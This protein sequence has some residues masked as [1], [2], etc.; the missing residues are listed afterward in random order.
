MRILYLSRWFPIPADNGARVRTLNVLKQ[1]SARHELTLLSFAGGKPEGDALA[2]ARTLCE[3]VVTVPYLGFQPDAGSWRDH[4]SRAPRSLRQAYSPEMQRQ[5]DLAI[6]RHKPDVI[7]AASLE[8][9]EYARGKKAGCVLEELELGLVQ[10]A[11]AAAQSPAARTQ[12]SLNWWKL[13]AYVRSVLRDFDAVTMVSDRERRRAEPL[14]LR[15]EQLFVCAN[16]IDAARYPAPST[17]DARTPRAGSLIY[18]G[19]LTYHANLDAVAYFLT[20]IYPQI[21]RANSG[22]SLTVTGD[23][24]GT[25]AHTLPLDDSVTLTGRVP[26]VRPVVASSWLT[27]VPLRI[28]GGTRIKIL[29]SLALGT[30]V[31]ST[32]K[33]AEGL[34]LSA[35]DGV[36]VADDPA[37]FAAHVQQLLADRALRDALGRAGRAAVLTRYSWSVIGERYEAVLRAAV[38]AQLAR[39]P[40]T[41]RAVRLT[42][43]SAGVL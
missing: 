13:A 14:T 16:G 17:V 3:E 30:P 10:D 8:M 32:T 37:Q 1:L 19:A 29:E 39:A 41:R 18:P 6:A 11:A 34:D 43:A 20:D 25:A 28:G 23:H 7:I 33:G 27:V 5:V 26:D 2:I 35:D 31:V 12:A 21:R 4:V 22:A 24:A 40:Q 38:A 42:R 36:L 15:P 9:A